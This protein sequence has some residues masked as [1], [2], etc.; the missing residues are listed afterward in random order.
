MDL[1]IP[2]RALVRKRNKMT[3]SKGFEGLSLTKDKKIPVI[4]DIGTAYTK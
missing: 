2:N 1:G 4:L 3:A